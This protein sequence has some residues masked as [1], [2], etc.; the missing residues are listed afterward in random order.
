V[1]APRRSHDLEIFGDHSRHVSP[2]IVLSFRGVYPFRNAKIAA[3]FVGQSRLESPELFDSIRFVPSFSM[4][5]KFL[6][7]DLDIVAPTMSMDE[8]IHC[9]DAFLRFAIRNQ[10]LE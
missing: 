10:G 5:Y 2:N 8:I 9:P 4:S 1:T 7:K 6:F 3:G